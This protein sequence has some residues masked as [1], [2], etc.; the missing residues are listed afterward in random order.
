MYSGWSLSPTL[1]PGWLE[2]VVEAREA[3]KRRRL[4]DV[5]VKQSS[6]GR[7]QR[8]PLLRVLVCRFDGFWFERI[9]DGHLSRRG[10]KSSF[11]G[12][13]VARV[14]YPEPG[15]ERTCVGTDVVAWVDCVVTPANFRVEASPALAQMISG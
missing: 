12:P 7:G 8:V 3:G 5:L 6:L 9:V 1:K 10:A 15:V 4:H 13:L 2:I 11:T 14:D